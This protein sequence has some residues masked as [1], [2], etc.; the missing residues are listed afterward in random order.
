M[1]VI[2]LPYTT[3]HYYLEW[4]F[5]TSVSVVL[6]YLVVWWGHICAR[7]KIWY[8]WALYILYSLY[9]WEIEMSYDRTSISGFLSEIDPRIAN[10]TH[11]SK[12]QVKKNF[13]SNGNHMFLVIED[14]LML[15][16]TLVYLG[17]LLS[18]SFPPSITSLSLQNTI[19]LNTRNIPWNPLHLILSKDSKN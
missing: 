10:N 11:C 8:F 9:I 13:D 1:N 18:V 12:S 15:L 17:D 16:K 3:I 6:P 7:A 2:S 19:Y 14:K 5:V 4:D